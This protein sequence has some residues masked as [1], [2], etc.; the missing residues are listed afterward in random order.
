MKTI[1]KFFILA[2]TVSMTCC[3][4]SDDSEYQVSGTWIELTNHFD[5]ISFENS[6]SEDILT[7]K[8]GY[9]YVN[10]HLLPKHGS[11]MYQFKLKP[12]SIMIN[13]ILWSCLCYP[14]YDFQMNSTH[15]TFEIGN[16]Y[17]T[18]L[19]ANQRMTFFRIQ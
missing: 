11:G 8:R 12:D 4:K 9:E 14:S 16:F 13:N 6:G 10:G 7:L 2:W 17:D 18:S 1:I 15:D 19:I 3:E 5:T